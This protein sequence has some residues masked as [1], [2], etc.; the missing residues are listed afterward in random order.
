MGPCLLHLS[1]AEVLQILQHACQVCCVAEQYCCIGV[2][3]LQQS[4]E[5]SAGLL[6]CPGAQV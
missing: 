6:G 1:M 2:Q 5:G 3:Q 4:I